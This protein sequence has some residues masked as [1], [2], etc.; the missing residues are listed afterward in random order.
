[1]IPG[2]DVRMVEFLKEAGEISEDPAEV[3]RIERLLVDFQ[4]E[5]PDGSQGTTTGPESP[6][7]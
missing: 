3:E 4:K 7:S 6:A 1:M 5:K 2:D